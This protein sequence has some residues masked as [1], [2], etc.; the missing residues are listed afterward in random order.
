MG[1]TGD[2]ILS[3]TG[4]WSFGGDTPSKF[5]KHVSKSVPLYKEGHDLICGMA[6]FFVPQ[7]GKVLHIGSSTGVLTNKVAK[8]LTKRD[9]QVIGLEIEPNMI[10]EAK[11]MENEKNVEFINDDIT[12]FEI[13]ENCNNLVIS[14][15]TIQFIHPSMRQLVIE[16]I[17]K[18]L[19]WGGAF[20]MFEKVR[21]SDARFQDIFNCFYQDFKSKQGYSADEILEKQRSL[22][23]I[24]EPFSRQGNIDM[25]K[26]AKFVDIESILKYACFEGFLSIK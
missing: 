3:E 18:S 8:T 26:R 11:R 21:G 20:I 14:Y 1:N 15:Y 7:N 9:A 5:N 13:G 25:L 10:K 19:M 24:L 4:L 22:K 12:T 17:Y 23:S 16:K 2:N 6:E